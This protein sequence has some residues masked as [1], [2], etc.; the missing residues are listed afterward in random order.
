MKSFFTS[1][2]VLLLAASSLLA[3]AQDSV[4]TQLALQ[5]RTTFSVE[6]AGFRG[7][8]WDTLLARIRASNDVLI[9]EDHFTNEIP[10]FTSAVAARVHFDNFFGE[11]DPYV[12]K[13]I[14]AK[15]RTL[16]KEASEKYLSNFEEVI[17]FYGKAPEARLL[18]QLLPSGTHF[19]GL[20]QVLMNADRLLCHD[21]KEK[22]K[23]ATARRL[24]DSIEQ[25]S[26]RAFAAFLK[27]P[28]QPMYLMTE[29]FQ[30]QLAAL[31]K[32][33]LRAMEVQQLND[34]ALSARIYREQNHELRIQLMKRNLLRAYAQVRDKKNLFK[35]GTN[36]IA[37]G[38][39]FFKIYDIG[40]VVHNLA[41]AEFGQSLH[42]LVVGRSGRQGS[43][44]KGFPAVNLRE[45]DGEH[46]YLKPLFRAA[47]PAGWS[48]FDL[49]PLRAAREGG[50]LV[51]SDVTFS[52]LVEGYDF[53]IVIPEVTPALFPGERQDAAALR[54]ND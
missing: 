25:K 17:A 18:R 8:G 13:L 1:C 33:P 35:F 49:R 10:F 36:H 44:F 29:D 24:Y 31:R 42:L 39:S 53:V 4:L 3:G 32:L 23:N 21:L 38:E 28:R 11:I 51:L 26:Q 37:R 52:R 19:F 41:D 9:G 46:A 15:L 22:T 34:L 47:A 14:E 54:T 50:R 48:C 30:R 27:D 20:D 2:L 12:A 45:D 5:G 6:G 43:P 40:N 16:P 7:A